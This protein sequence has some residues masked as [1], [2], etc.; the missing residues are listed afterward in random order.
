[1]KGKKLVASD[2]L[3]PVVTLED[4]SQPIPASEI[5]KL[6]R[7]VLEREKAELM[8]RL[9][10]QR[11]EMEARTLLSRYGVEMSGWRL[12]TDAGKMTRISVTEA[13]GNGSNAGN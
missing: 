12:D 5:Q 13:G 9:A 11:L 1:M 7:F 4:E 3:L 10:D 2:P 6:H 8:L